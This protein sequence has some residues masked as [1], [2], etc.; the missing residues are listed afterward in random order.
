MRP[1]IKDVAKEAGVSPATVSLVLN[2]SALPISNET[3]EKVLQVANQLN[4]RPNMLAVSLAK[5]RSNSIGLILPDV[6]NPFFSSISKSIQLA[7]MEKNY[8]VVACSTNDDFISTCNYLRCFSDRGMDGIILTQSNFQSE[9]DNITIL[10]LLEEI[11][12]HIVLID[13]VYETSKFPAV[14]VDQEKAGYLATQ[15][16]LESG[17]RRIG[18]VAGPLGIYG[19]KKRLGGYIKALSEYGIEYDPSLVFEGK[20]DL[21][22]GISSVPYL[23]GKKVTGVFCFA[24]Y[25]ATGVYQGIRNLDRRIPEDLSIVSIDDTILAETVQPPLTSVAQPIEK[26]ASVAVDTLISLIN[27]ESCEYGICTLEPAVKVRSSI[28]RL[29]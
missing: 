17:H 13:R 22:T 25:I 9:K 15:V 4:Y 23:L 21:Q 27:H 11:Q 10:N 29:E 3:K 20:Y 5:K 7:A 6:C 2:N 12:M 16:L 19:S 1:T 8:A 18:C 26:I 14:L 28:K 24:D